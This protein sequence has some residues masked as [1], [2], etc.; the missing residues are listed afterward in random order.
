MMIASI[1]EGGSV[2][3]CRR[4][5]H[6]APQVEEFDAAYWKGPILYG[7]RGVS[8]GLGPWHD[9]GPAPSRALASEHPSKRLRRDVVAA[10]CEPATWRPAIGSQDPTGRGSE[11]SVVERS[12]VSALLRSARQE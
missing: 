3:M 8:L 6:R 1:V 11:I 2:R 10:A 12:D 5:E 7:P 4:S 9:D